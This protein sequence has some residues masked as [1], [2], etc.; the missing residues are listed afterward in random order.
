[1]V[2][3]REK[4]VPAVA[5]AFLLTGVLSSIY[6]YATEIS[7]D[8]F[9]ING[10]EY[11]IDQIFF[12]AE[13]RSLETDDG[14]FSGVALDD[15]MKKA[16]VACGSCHTYTIIGSDGYSKTVTWENLQHGVLTEEKRVVFSD[17]PKAFRVRDVV[18]IEVK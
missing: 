18:N 1:M 16:G 6:V 11:T 12:I 2:M 7:A 9:T 17:L 3:G 13:H 14:N 4:L 15:L 10:E 5:V 8:T